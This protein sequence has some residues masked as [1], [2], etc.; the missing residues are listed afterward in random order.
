MMLKN[1]VLGKILGPSGEEIRRYR[2]LHFIRERKTLAGHVEEKFI[3][4]FVG[5]TWRKGLGV[6]TRIILKYI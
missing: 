6:D 3:Q 1:R 5:K 4:I 2:K